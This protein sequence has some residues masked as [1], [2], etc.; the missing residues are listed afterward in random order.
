MQKNDYHHGDLRNALISAGVEALAEQGIQ[1][2]SLRKLAKE[3]GVSHNAPYQHFKD[4]EALVAAIA[5]QGFYML[6][7]SVEQAAD[8]AGDGALKRLHSAA[9]SYVGFAMAHPH[10]FW[11]MFQPYDIQRFQ[12]LSVAS[13]QS[14]EQL[15]GLVRAGQDADVL[16]GG[17]PAHL[18]TTVWALLHGIA[19]ILAA[20]KLPPQVDQGVSPQQL[21]A[22]FLAR[23]L[24]GIGAPIP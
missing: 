1:G 23:L 21:A 2:L 9:Q 17:D 7:E 5:E 20:N 6:T 22:I 16:Q 18:A 4:K 3:L 10:H 15:V 12:A 11:A 24:H 19:S 14:F 13:I 8:A